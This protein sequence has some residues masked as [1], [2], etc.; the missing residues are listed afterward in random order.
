MLTIIAQAEAEGLVPE[1]ITQVQK[2][3]KSL[4]KLENLYYSE[5]KKRTRRNTC[6]SAALVATVTRMHSAT[7]GGQL[8]TNGFIKK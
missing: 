6:D 5:K 4:F 8:N 3:L 2:D 7:D 1:M